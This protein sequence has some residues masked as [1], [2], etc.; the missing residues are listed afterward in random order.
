MAQL[1]MPESIAEANQELIQGML[2]K[3]KAA[4]QKQGLNENAVAPDPQYQVRKKKKKPAK[5]VESDDEEEEEEKKEAD[6]NGKDME[7]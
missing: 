4:A 2:D 5:K 1:L 6:E 3:Q 7:D